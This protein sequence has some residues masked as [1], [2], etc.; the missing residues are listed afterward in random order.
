MDKNVTTACKA[1]VRAEKRRERA[2]QNK[3]DMACEA[4]RTKH[5][6]HTC[7]ARHGQHVLQQDKFVASAV[8]RKRQ[9]PRKL[10]AEN[11]SNKAATVAR[12][13][14][15]KAK[16]AALR[17][18]RQLREQSRK[19]LLKALWEHV[20]QPPQGRTLVGWAVESTEVDERDAEQLGAGRII[21]FTRPAQYVVEWANE[22]RTE[23]GY[24]DLF[25]S[26]DVPL[27]LPLGQLDKSHPIVSTPIHRTQHVP[28]AGSKRARSGRVPC[29]TAQSA[30]HN[31]FTR[32]TQRQR[33]VSTNTFEV[34]D[35]VKVLYD[36][37][38]THGQKW[39]TGTVQRL[40]KSNANPSTYEYTVVVRSPHIMQ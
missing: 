17:A 35:Y 15:S 32:S 19:F 4:C 25:R 10:E 3:H 8:T 22:S 33:T 2:A 39:Y 27:I 12:G 26:D 1:C 6:I 11:W 38:D 36:V 34:G 5:G 28:R 23:Y 21:S 20:A 30:T 40:F 18:E 37:S 24:S 13:N 9:A 29:S 31:G 14:G 16:E 7:P